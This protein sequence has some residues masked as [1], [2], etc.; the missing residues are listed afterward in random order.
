[1]PIDRKLVDTVSQYCQRNCKVCPRSDYRYRHHLDSTECIA[2]AMLDVVDAWIK[3]H[4]DMD[5][6]PKRFFVSFVKEG[7]EHYGNAVVTCDD[8]V[9]DAEGLDH[10]AELVQGV[11]GEP[12]FLTNYRRM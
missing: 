8:D 3:Q 10:L 12:I 7:S 9:K 2:H 4:P 5:S 6:G 11:V 1:M